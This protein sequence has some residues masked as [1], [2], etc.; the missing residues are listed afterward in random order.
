MAIQNLTMKNVTVFDEISMDF[1]KGVNVL[2]GSNGMGKTHIMKLLYSAC[3]AVRI[4]ESFSRKVVMTFRPDNFALAQLINRN[5]LQ[6]NAS[7]TVKSDTAEIGMRFDSLT[8]ER[9]AE[10]TGEKQWELENASLKSVFIPAKE[11]LT[12]SF[13][14]INA[15]RSQNVEFD[16]SY[17]DH[18]ASATVMDIS[19]DIGESEETLLWSLLNNHELLTRPVQDVQRDQD[20]EK[21]SKIRNWLKNNKQFTKPVQDLQRTSKVSERFNDTLSAKRNEP[22]QS[23]SQPL[24][25]ILSRIETVIG[26][27]VIFDETQHF[28]LVGN[29]GRLEFNLVAEGL[30]KIALLWQLIRNGALKPG[31]ALFWDEPEANL[32]P[33]HIPLIA[34]LLL[35]LQ[36]DGV[37]VF[38]STHDYFLARYLD[39]RAK[40]DDEI[41]FFSLYKEKNDNAVRHEMERSFHDL[42]HNPIK[43]TFNKLY[44]EEIEQWME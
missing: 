14:L 4:D 10:I 16:D 35:Q 23:L 42:K 3:Q 20:E 34:D 19:L 22:P 13:N 43:D 8:E 15:V 44:H 1:S 6:Q 32:N 36:R 38:V 9:N 2:I 25:E 28:Y 12:H 18:L 17:I 11:M 33:E 5:S 27:T 24:K 21:I 26:G 30:R 37:Q 41:A 40:D 29:S 7:V 39:V 31:A